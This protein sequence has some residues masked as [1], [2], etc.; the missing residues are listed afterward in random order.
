MSDLNSD[1][2]LERHA[3]ENLVRLIEK[4][5][6]FG[7]YK[8]GEFKGYDVPLGMFRGVT[9]IG[10]TILRRLEKKLPNVLIFE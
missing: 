10:Y 8:L 5:R 6:R 3:R 4:K 1:S 9:G 2:D 7:V